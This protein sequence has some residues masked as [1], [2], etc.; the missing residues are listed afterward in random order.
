M[1]IL[2]DYDHDNDYDDDDINDSRYGD[3]ENQ[4]P[5]STA[6]KRVQT[7]MPNTT[8]TSMTQQFIANMS[9]DSLPSYC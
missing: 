7:K 9:Q 4:R 8:K 6:T 1:M 2:S 5:V 3:T